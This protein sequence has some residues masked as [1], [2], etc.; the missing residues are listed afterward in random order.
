MKIALS[1]TTVELGVAMGQAV[2]Q[3]DS[4]V[5]LMAPDPRLAAY[6]GVGALLHD[7]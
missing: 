1:I 4:L 2:L 6:G 7:Q 3:T 5:E